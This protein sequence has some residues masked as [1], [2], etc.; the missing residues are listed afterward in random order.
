VALRIE[1]GNGLFACFLVY[2]GRTKV[3]APGENLI[4]NPYL[5]LAK[6]SS[7]NPMNAFLHVSLVLWL[8]LM[9]QYQRRLCFAC[10]GLC[11]ITVDECILHCQGQHQRRYDK[12]ILKSSLSKSPF[13]SSTSSL[14]RRS[15]VLFLESYM[16]TLYVLSSSSHD[17]CVMH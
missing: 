6:A 10:I 2:L 13:I 17:H 15:Y 4:A 14:Y 9:N 7:V 3:A 16:S 5:R 1:S 11:G 12:Y 8:I